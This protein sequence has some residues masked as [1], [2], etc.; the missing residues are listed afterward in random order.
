MK[1]KAVAGWN[2]LYRGRNSAL[3]MAKIAEPSRLN[4]GIFEVSYEPDPND[5]GKQIKIVHYDQLNR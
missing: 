5:S 1:D 2:S 3:D 4:T